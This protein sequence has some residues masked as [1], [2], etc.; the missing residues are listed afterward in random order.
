[1]T[2]F[3]LISWEDWLGEGCRSVK[4]CI[5]IGHV[6]EFAAILYMT[7]NEKNGFLFKL[8]TLLIVPRKHQGAWQSLNDY[9]NSAPHFRQLPIMALPLKKKRKHECK[10]PAGGI[11]MHSKERSTKH[12]HVWVPTARRA[13]QHSIPAPAKPDETLFILIKVFERAPDC[14]TMCKASYLIFWQRLPFP[15]AFLLTSFPWEMLSRSALVFHFAL[16]FSFR[17]ARHR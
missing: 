1:M 11:K 3:E 2:V 13:L 14:P 10:V 16:C 8:E 7:P 12:S 9:V 15:R 6:D 17:L 4:V 5:I